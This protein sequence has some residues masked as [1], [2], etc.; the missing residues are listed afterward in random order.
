MSQEAPIEMTD[1]LGLPELIFVH[2][3]LIGHCQY[4]KNGTYRG[5]SIEG[6]G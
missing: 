1:L 2:A 5:H 4:S 3:N 6:G